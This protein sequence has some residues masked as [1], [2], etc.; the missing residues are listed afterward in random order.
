MTVSGHESHRDI[1]QCAFSLVLT[2]AV[3]WPFIHK[4]DKIATQAKYVT[5]QQ[6]ALF[7]ALLPTTHTGWNRLEK[8]QQLHKH[9]PARVLLAQREK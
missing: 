8:E 7:P 3:T 4:T 5:S 2:P 1:W 6:P 9:K